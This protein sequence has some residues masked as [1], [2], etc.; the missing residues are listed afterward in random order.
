MNKKMITYDFN[1]DYVDIMLKY[2]D[3]EYAFRAGDGYLE[4]SD[5]PVSKSTPC[6]ASSAWLSDGTFSVLAYLSGPEMGTISIQ[7]AFSENAVTVLMH[8]YGEVSFTGFEGVFTG[9]EQGSSSGV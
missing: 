2:R 7:S 1:K 8:L 4:K 3:S 9:I 5:F 6:Y